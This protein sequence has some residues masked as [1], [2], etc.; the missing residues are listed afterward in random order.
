MRILKVI[1]PFPD[2]VP[3]CNK[4]T[5]LVLWLS[6]QGDIDDGT[7]PQFKISSWRRLLWEIESRPS[8]TGQP[9][10]EVPSIKHLATRV[11]DV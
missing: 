2:L 1:H 7:L 11:K 5:K 3:L 9:S 8:V 6:L 4:P 10:L